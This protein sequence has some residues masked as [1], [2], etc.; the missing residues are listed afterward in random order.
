MNQKKVKKT[1]SQSTTPHT[2]TEKREEGVYFTWT[3]EEIDQALNKKQA[4]LIKNYY[5]VTS[6]GNFEGRNIFYVS[7]ELSETAKELKLDILEA[8]KLLISSWET[9]YQ[10][11]QLRPL[12][13]R[14]EKN[15]LRLERFN[16]LRF[17]LRLFYFK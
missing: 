7:K 10:T 11:R 12:P 14:D 13:L 8:K 5:G 17:C 2:D 16:D 9:L 4:E 3:I 1:L 6:V 15:S